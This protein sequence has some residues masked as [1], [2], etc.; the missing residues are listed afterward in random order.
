MKKTLKVFNSVFNNPHMWDE[1]CIIVSKTPPNA[2]QAQFDSWTKSSPTKKCRRDCFIELLHQLCDW[3]GEDPEFPLFFVDSID[4]F[5]PR[6]SEFERFID[7]ACSR[8][9]TRIDPT[10]MIPFR[11]DVMKEIST[12]RKFQEEVRRSNTKLIGTRK[13]RVHRDVPVVMTLTRTIDRP[14]DALDVVTFGIAWLFR[15]KRATETYTL[16]R[17]VDD[18][19]EIDEPIYQGEVIVDTVEIEEKAMITFDYSADRVDVTKLEEDQPGRK[20]GA[21]RESNRKILGTKVEIV[22]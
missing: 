4:P 9:G 17:M 1:V 8:A 22:T 18:E 5:G 13:R 15:S 21:W 3:Q 6:K 20:V 19:R 10:S 7:F 12:T 16:T 14:V 2:T 11:R